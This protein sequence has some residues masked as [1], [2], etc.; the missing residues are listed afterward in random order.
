MLWNETQPQHPGLQVPVSRNCSALAAI[1]LEIV[2]VDAD[3]KLSHFL[4]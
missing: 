1:G 4:V 2:G 3:R